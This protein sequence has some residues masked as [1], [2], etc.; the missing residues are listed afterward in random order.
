MATPGFGS[1]PKPGQVHRVEV[2]RTIIARRLGRLTGGGLFGESQKLGAEPSWRESGVLGQDSVQNAAYGGKLFWLW[3]DTT[4][5]RYP[6]GVFDS[7]SATTARQ[8]LASFEPPLRL[9]LDYF[10]DEKGVPRGTA[11]MPGSGPTWISALASLPDAQGREHLAATYVKVQGFLHVYRKGLAVWD[12]TT[13]S[14]KLFRLLWEET[15]ASPHPPP[16]PDG[17]AVP[18]NRRGGETLGAV[19]QSVPHDALPGDV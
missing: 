5:P 14:F 4:L 7:T 3:G 11:K 9:P 17:H 19:L 13:E 6:L 15:A 18:W 12:D 2:E 8:P 1:R 10:R 16:T